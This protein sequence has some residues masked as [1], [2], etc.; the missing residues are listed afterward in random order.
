MSDPFEIPE[1]P[2][3]WFENTYIAKLEAK[4]KELERQLAKYQGDDKT[5]DWVDADERRRE[6]E[7][8]EHARRIARKEKANQRQESESTPANRPRTQAPRK[9]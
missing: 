7:V 2:W 8:L 3:R 1:R 6:K 5:E 9:K 4:I